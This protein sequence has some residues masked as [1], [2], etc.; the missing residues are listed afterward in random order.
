MNASSEQIHHLEN[1]IC[2]LQQENSRLR[3]LLDQAG[4][5]YEQTTQKEDVQD[6]IAPVPITEA[7]AALLYSVFKGRKDVFSRRGIR[8][9][10]GASYFP[11]CDNFWKAGIC[12]KQAGLKAK[13]M[14]CSHRKW[15]PL[16]KRALMNHLMGRKADSTDVI[17]IYPLLPDETCNFLVFD[18]D[19]HE[20]DVNDEKGD[21]SS[22][23]EEVDALRAICKL[24]QVDVLTERSRSGKGAHIWIFFEEP[25]PAAL[26]RKFG[27][28]LLT[29]GAESIN[30][31]NFKS[32]DRML[33]A[34]DTLPQGGLGNLIALPLQGQALRKG[35]SA[36]IDEFWHAYPDQWAVLQ[37]IKRL[38]RAWIEER[39]R[40]WT[41]EA[42]VLGDLSKM[43]ESDTPKEKPWEKKK[44]ALKQD[45]VVGS[46]R[47]TLANQIY[48]ET[49]NLKPAA[50]NALRRM[51]AFSN[52]QFYRNQAMGFSVK[53]IPRIIWCGGEEDGYILLPRG[54]QEELIAQA[55]AAGIPY[56]I[57]DRREKGNPIRV[58][59]QGTLY[60]EQQVA[61]ERM[62][63]YDCGVLHAATA[64]GKTAVGAA[65]IARRKVNTLI[66]V[67][68][69]EIMK[70]WVD[71]LQKFL[72]IEEEPPT[73]TTSTGKSR[74]RKSVIGTLY[75]AHDSVTGIIDVAMITSLGTGDGI[76][77]RIRSYGLVL[78]DECHHAGAVNAEAVLREISAKYVYGLTATPKRDD[79]ME[80][81]VFMQFGPIRHRFTA[82][83]RIAAQGFTCL[84]R[85]RFTSLVHVGKPLKIQD[86]YRAVIQDE[87]RNHQ[88]IEDVKNCISEGHSPLVLTKFRE[89][90]ALLFDA[91]KEQADHVFLLQGGRSTKERNAIREAM[92]Q[93]PANESVILVAIGQY[94]GEGFNFPRLDT[95]MLTTPIAW[96]GN[97]EQYAGRLHRAYDG[98]SVVTI[99]DYIDSHVRVLEQMFRKRLRAYKKI[100]YQIR[101]DEC[102]KN[103]SKQGIFDSSQVQEA[104]EKDILAANQ[105]II[106]SSPGLN[107]QRVEWLIDL[108]PTLYRRNTRVTI[109]TLSADSYP[110]ERKAVAQELI[111]RLKRTDVWV[112][113]NDQIHEHFAVIDGYIVW[114]GS[115]NLL[116]RVKE[117]EEMLRL[118]DREIANELLKTTICHFS[119]M[120]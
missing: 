80:Q 104:F 19:D 76:D 82:K 39:I 31:K 17:G 70:N 41:P 15:T 90:A 83:E 26:A 10:G 95:L 94:I 118:V 48:I 18:F 12:P 37:Q 88:I 114:Y 79:G 77:E 72:N 62:L 38:T 44:P 61:V 66:L 112:E 69:R 50:K 22:W 100:G 56:Q 29:K 97:V 49:A 52:P 75:A 13:C 96:E 54:K 105:E 108:L 67:H 86:A 113:T 24:H 40:E 36:F 34:Q 60:P 73:Y 98:K 63:A 33:P 109:L 45:S 32:Y 102:R 111:Q 81:K 115:V 87:K 23:T 16:T 20:S 3:L 74:H 43:E 8:K 1:E 85:P 84:V 2:R 99:Y 93:V 57:T 58:Q 28:A 42:G 71:D 35:N 68:N 78:M 106:L 30:Q 46:L 64:F 103:D 53:G 47:I 117:D 65:L 110:E 120:E 25:L 51:A 21:D 89:H 7:H 27:A 92:E 116:S 55:Q 59:F 4:I 119:E 91:L 14:E 101:K 9:D 107:K 5:C 6:T 11:Q